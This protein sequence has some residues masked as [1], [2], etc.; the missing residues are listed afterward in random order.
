M[1]AGRD[2]RAGGTWLGVTRS[3]RWAALTYDGL[4]L[5]VGDS[6]GVQYSFLP[7]P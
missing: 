4:N 5:L 2:L 3:G 6:S 1:L 7:D